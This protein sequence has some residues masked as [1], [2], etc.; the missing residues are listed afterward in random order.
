MQRTITLSSR[1]IIVTH[2]LFYGASHALRDYLNGKKIPHLLFV[3][4]PVR[5]ENQRSYRQ[6]F[7][8]GRLLSERQLRRP[9]GGVW[10]YI[11]DFFLSIVWILREQR[12]YD[13]YIG[14]DP[15]NCLGGVILKRLGVTRR[16][17]FYSI[18]FTPRRFANRVLNG[19][20]HGI[21]WI[22]VRFSDER[23]DVSPRIGFAREAMLGLSGKRYPARIVPVGVWR[24][25]IVGSS[26]YDPHRFAFVGHLLPKQGVGKVIDALP[27][28][29]KR[30]GD[31][32][33]LVLGGGEE[34]GRL[35]RRAR[36]LGVVK[37]VEFCGWI[38]DQKRVQELL[39]RCA[40]G[41]ALYEPRGSRAENFTYYADPTKIKTYL[42]CGLPVV[43]TD[44]PYNA[45]D[46]ERS[47][48]ATVV[49]YSKQAIA[50]ALIRWLTDQEELEKARKKAI[51]VART[52]TWERIFDEVFL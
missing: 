22:C 17:V 7:G 1:I 44:V 10:W 38:D 13:V 32:T 39:S 37:H 29:R 20:Y 25:N 49:P 30:V 14:V 31:A 15:L 40:F 18:D 33:F 6:I 47:C 36:K 41:V 28:V 35:R 52:F 46:L 42:S 24:Q 48:C 34:E 45:K 23:W 5:P 26:L 21:E 19:V 16:V 8:N 9:A 11:F 12:V 43:L 3:S 51:A 4:H 50:A 2:E 27:L